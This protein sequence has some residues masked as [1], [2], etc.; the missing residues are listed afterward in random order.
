MI[1]V[2]IP[3]F[4]RVNSTLRCINSLLNQVNVKTKIIVVDDG[5]TDRTKEILNEVYPEVV[6]LRGDGNMYWTG[7]VHF[8]IEYVKS[9]A[10]DNDWVILANNDVQF[11]DIQTIAKLVEFSVSKNRM[12]LVS[13]L[14]LDIKCQDRTIT[15]GTIVTSWFF[16]TTKHIYNNIKYENVLKSP[17][18]VDMLTARCLLHPIEIFDIVGNYNYKIFPHYGGDDDFS[19]RSMRNGYQPYVLPYLCVSLDTEKSCKFKSY[20][21]FSLIHFLLFNRLSSINIPDKIKFALENV[22]FWAR[23]SYIIA[24]IVKSV[25]FTIISVAK[26]QFNNIFE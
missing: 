11:K 14:S 17:V 12:S 22:H 24:A 4:N 8:G 19:L 5:S 2:V 23:G 7:A 9:V 26:K 13:P 18:K 10:H 6:V 25:L 20:N 1:Y 21:G 3:V 15:S 16:N